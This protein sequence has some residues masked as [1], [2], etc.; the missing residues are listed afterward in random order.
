MTTAAIRFMIEKNMGTVKQRQEL[1]DEV[2]QA[3]GNFFNSKKL[4]IDLKLF[5]EYIF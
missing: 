3:Y 5:L 2:A 4:F 1:L